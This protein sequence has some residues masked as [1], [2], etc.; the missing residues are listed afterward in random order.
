MPAYIIV[1]VEV[2][3]PETYKTYAAQVAPI[4]QQY[5]GEFLVRGGGMEI[6]EGDWPY[7]RVVVLKFPDM[8]RAKAWHASAE[9][10]APKALRQSASKGNMIVV[11]GA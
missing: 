11:D 9:Y 1:Q 6:L 4:L 10:E 7:P 5:G 8:E 3:D 2:T